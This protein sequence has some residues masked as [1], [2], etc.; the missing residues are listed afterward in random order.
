MSCIVIFI[1]NEYSSKHISKVFVCRV[2]LFDRQHG[3]SIKLSAGVVIQQMVPAA[4][5][6]INSFNRFW[7]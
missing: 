5:A 6:G 7:L 2:L 4:A 3:Q 1:V